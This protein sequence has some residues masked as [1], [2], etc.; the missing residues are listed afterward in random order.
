MS[1]EDD[2][3]ILDMQDSEFPIS[4][5]FIMQVD[6]RNKTREITLSLTVVVSF[7]LL[8]VSTFRGQPLQQ[9]ETDTLRLLNQNS[10]E[11]DLS[12]HHTNAFNVYLAVDCSLIHSEPISSAAST[13]RVSLSVTIRIPSGTAIY[14]SSGDRVLTFTEGAKSD[15]LLL[16]YDKMVYRANY[17]ISVR[18]E[19]NITHFSEFQIT[20]RLG[21]PLVCTSL[22]ATKIYCCLWALGTLLSLAYRIRYTYKNLVHLCL[23]QKITIFL[24]VLCFCAD[25]PFSGLYIGHPALGLILLRV[26]IGSLFRISIRFYIVMIFDSI[27]CQRKR[28]NARSSWLISAFFIVMFIFD[29]VAAVAHEID[30]YRTKLMETPRIIVTGRSIC[31]LVCDLFDVAYIVRAALNLD[32]TEMF[33]F[34]VYIVHTV[35][36]LL[37]ST[38]ASR[39]K[40]QNQKD[41]MNPILILMEFLAQNGFVFF[42]ND[43]HLPVIGTSKYADPSRAIN[44]A[45]VEDEAEVE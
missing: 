33:R 22:I 27:C 11:V 20:A 17:S 37:V 9:K 15:P 14:H 18:I 13:E 8:L 28:E 10:N 45:F 35:F 21:N 29:A 39:I 16:F 40:V 44:G 23:E 36:F 19:S 38:T 2:L 42:M 6:K 31:E 24:L 26:I 25:D 30:A 34:T 32:E 5:R 4:N 41:E 7:V 3:T 12:L 43:A 1:S